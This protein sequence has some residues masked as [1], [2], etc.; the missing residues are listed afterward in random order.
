M[1]GDGIAV[2]SMRP[3]EFTGGKMSLKVSIGFQGGSA[4][5][6]PPEFTGG[7]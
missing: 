4:S 3:P 2:A 6:R 1:P 7:K 5:M